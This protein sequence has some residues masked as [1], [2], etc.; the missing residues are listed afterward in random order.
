MLLSDH[1]DTGRQKTLHINQRDNTVETESIWSVDLL[2]STLTHKCGA[3]VVFENGVVMDVDVIP[4]SFSSADIRNLLRSARRTF[5]SEFKN[6]T[7]QPDVANETQTKSGR[8]LLS[9]N[10]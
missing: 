5:A 3:V 6:R 1:T 2:G 9:L 4:K 7:L 8:P 10:R